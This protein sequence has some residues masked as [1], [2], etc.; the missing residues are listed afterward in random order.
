MWLWTTYLYSGLLVSHLGIENQ[1]SEAKKNSHVLS[2][3][4]SDE[5]LLSILIQCSKI[6]CNISD[7]DIDTK[8]TAI[9]SHFINILGLYR[10]NMIISKHAE[11]MDHIM[12]LVC[13]PPLHFFILDPLGSS[14]LVHHQIWTKLLWAAVTCCTKECLSWS[15]LIGAWWWLSSLPP[16]PP[17]HPSHFNPTY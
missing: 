14:P 15:Y 3:Q 13:P 10:V 4:N 2:T 17:T 11:N 7:T 16:F 12:Q 6:K 8:I 1:S 9:Y 5:I